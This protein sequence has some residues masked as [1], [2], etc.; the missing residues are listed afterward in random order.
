[1]F[2][3]EGDIAMSR[4][5]DSLRGL[6]IHRATETLK[7][8]IQRLSAIY[9]GTTDTEVREG[10]SNELRRMGIRIESTPIW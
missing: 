2:S 9:P 1:M 10:V 3:V 4:L 5:I 8:G 6:D 7:C